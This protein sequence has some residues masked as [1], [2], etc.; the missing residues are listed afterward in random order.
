MRDQF[1]ELR[2]GPGSEFANAEALHGF[3]FALFDP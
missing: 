2:S 1:Q 3:Y